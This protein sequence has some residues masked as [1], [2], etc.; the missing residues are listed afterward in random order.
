MPKGRN[1]VRSASE[2]CAL[3]GASN[4]ESGSPMPE[5]S[6]VLSAR[7]LVAAY[8]RSRADD[9]PEYIAARQNLAALQLERHVQKVLATAPRP[10]DEQLQRIAGLL[11]RSGAV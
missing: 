7:G 1:A 8:S 4:P 9:D 2:K 11:V 6:S 5:A 10:S 3:S